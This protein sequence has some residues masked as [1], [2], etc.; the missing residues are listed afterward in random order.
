MLNALL[1]TVMTICLICL[2]SPCLAF[3]RTKQYLLQRTKPNR[4]FTDI[5]QFSFASPNDCNNDSLALPSRAKLLPNISRYR[6]SVDEGYGRGGKKLGVPTANLPSSLFKNALEGVTTGVYFGWAALERGYEKNDDDDDNF[7]V[8]KAV[9]NV[10]YS[11]T[12]EGKENKEKIIEA[13]LILEKD[14]KQDDN[15]NGDDD[16]ETSSLIED[17][18]GIPM[19]LQLIGFLREEKKFDSFPELIAQIHAD[20]DDARLSLDCKPYQLCSSDKFFSSLPD[21]WIGNGGGDEGASWDSEPIQSY[22]DS[23]D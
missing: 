17:F 8:Y 16:G 2:P 22:L 20:V 3:S 15:I 11:P 9:V 18:Y 1:P 6:G 14:S 4:R 7:Q 23:L 21:N 13:H 5:R 10:G 12:F 19:R